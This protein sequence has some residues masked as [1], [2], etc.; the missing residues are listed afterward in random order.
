MYSAPTTAYRRS[1]ALYSLAERYPTT[2]RFGQP[3][4]VDP[5]AG[6]CEGTGGDAPSE[7]LSKRIESHSDLSP[8]KGTEL[9][10]DAC[11]GGASANEIGG[12]RAGRCRLT[13]G[14]DGSGQCLPSP[15][16]GSRAEWLPGG[17]SSMW[18]PFRHGGC[19]TCKAR[20]EVT[21]DMGRVREIKPSSRSR[22]ADAERGHCVESPASGLCRGGQV[23]SKGVCHQCIPLAFA[24]S[25]WTGAWYAG[26]GGDAAARLTRAR[27]RRRGSSRGGRG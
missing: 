15:G 26:D 12:A 27:R 5:H 3:A 23:V 1:Q 18:A 16:A 8:Q 7:C 6:W 13:P 25:D 17:R 9:G 22:G 10:A 21:G 20:S 11:S 19:G 14:E 24:S 4:S 2:G